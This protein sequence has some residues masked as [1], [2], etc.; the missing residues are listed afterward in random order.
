MITPKAKPTGGF[1]PTN[2]HL[3]RVLLYQIELCRHK[4]SISVTIRTKNSCKE[5]VRPNAH[6]PYYIFKGLP[7]HGVMC[8]PFVLLH[9]IEPRLAPGWESCYPV[10][11]TTGFPLTLKKQKLFLIK[12]FKQQP[13]LKG[14]SFTSATGRI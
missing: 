11:Y 7:S 6:A 9:G 2:L 13:D 4:W 8:T 3:T 12:L 5:F 14:S 1:E 10:L